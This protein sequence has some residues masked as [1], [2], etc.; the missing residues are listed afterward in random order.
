LIQSPQLNFIFPF[1]FSA[2]PSFFLLSF[3]CKKACKS[4]HKSEE[5]GSRM[6][7]KENARGI[8]SSYN[9]RQL[10]TAKKRPGQAT[11]S[12]ARIPRDRAQRPLRQKLKTRN[13]NHKREKE[14]QLQA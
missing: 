5:S 12:P 9:I 10:S 2:F 1:F 6:C 8:D 7:E 13:L 3:L 14:L 11:E 4:A